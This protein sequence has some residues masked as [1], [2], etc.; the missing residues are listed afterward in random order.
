MD[1]QNPIS[2]IIYSFFNVMGEETLP[3]ES[4]INE[5][6]GVSDSIRG[7]DGCLIKLG[8]R[9]VGNYLNIMSRIPILRSR[10]GSRPD[11]T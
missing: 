7:G 11:K 6:V 10:G 9:E 8:Q 4:K 3:Y 1:Y 2:E 5:E